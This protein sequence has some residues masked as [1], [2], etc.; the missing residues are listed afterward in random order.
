VATIALPNKEIGRTPGGNAG[1]T[2]AGTAHN[3]T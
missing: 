3:E 2:R 1:N